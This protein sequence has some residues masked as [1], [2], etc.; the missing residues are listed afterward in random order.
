[1]KD[2]VFAM[3]TAYIN[4]VLANERIDYIRKLRTV[5]KYEALSGAS[6]ENTLERMA[7]AELP[8]LEKWIVE[9]SVRQMLSLLSETEATVLYCVVCQEEPLLL[10]SERLGLSLKSVSRIKCRALAKLRDRLEKGS[11]EDVI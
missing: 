4:R 5:E 8:P 7:A 1:M 9:D 2:E 10:V 6:Y 11:A 3:F